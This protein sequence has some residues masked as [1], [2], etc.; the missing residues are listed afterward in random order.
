M[1]PVIGEYK[2]FT[3]LTKQT[4]FDTLRIQGDLK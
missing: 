3:L 4:S 1:N 2:I